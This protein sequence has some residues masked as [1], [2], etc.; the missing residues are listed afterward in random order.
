MVTR[1]V[2]KEPNVAFHS[3]TV[4]LFAIEKLMA[5]QLPESSSKQHLKD[6]RGGFKAIKLAFFDSVQ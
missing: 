2:S 5:F 4:I 3:Q 6:E 1:C